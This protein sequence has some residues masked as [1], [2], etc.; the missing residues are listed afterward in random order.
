ML[1]ISQERDDFIISTKLFE[2][3]FAESYRRIRSLR[4]RAKMRECRDRIFSDPF[5]KQSREK[6][7]KKVL[8]AKRRKRDE[9]G[10]F[11]EGKK[12]KACKSRG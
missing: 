10:L 12:R 2:R 11:Y 8:A 3:D 4:F 7:I 9:A 1:A 6:N 5:H